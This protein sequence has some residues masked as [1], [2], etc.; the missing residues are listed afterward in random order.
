MTGLC[1]LETSPCGKGTDSQEPCAVCTP[2]SADG[3]RKL[4]SVGKEVLATGLGQSA[5]LSM[6]WQAGALCCLGHRN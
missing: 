1:G 4:D 6:G 3:L 5:V 2:G